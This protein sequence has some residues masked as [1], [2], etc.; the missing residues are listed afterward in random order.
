MTRTSPPQPS[1]SSG[2]LDPLLH[3]RDDY[4][5]YRTGLAKCR[6]FIPLPQGGFTRQPGTLYQ[7]R[8]LSDGAAVLVPFEF[9]ADDAVVLE[10]TAGKM[11]VWRYGALVMNGAGTAPYELATPYDAA[12]LPNL[13]W[14]QSA[15]VVYM[16]DGLRP[17][18]RLARFALNNWTIG[19]QP[20]LSGPFAAQNLDKGKTVQASATTGN[21]TLTANSDL[22]QAG[23]I[24]GLIMLQ[25][26]D[27]TAVAIWTSNTEV[28]ADA[29][30]RVGTRIYRQASGSARTTLQDSPIHEEGIHN[31]GGDILWEFVSDDIGIAQITAISS[32]TVASATVLRA[33]PPGVKDSAT[34]RWS[35]GAWSAQNGYPSAL[36]IYEQRLV[37]AATPSDPRTVWFSTIGAYN[38]FTPGTDADSAFAYT[39]AGSGSINRILN[40]ARGRSGLHIFALGEEHSVRSENRGAPLGPTTAVFG[41]DGSNGTSPAAPI[42]PNGDP[43]VISRD[44]RRVMTVAYSLQ[45]DGNQVAVMSRSAQHLGAETFDQIVWQSS[46]EPMAWLRRGNGEFATMIYDPSE[47]ILGWARASVAGGFV[48]SLC[49][50]K[51]ALGRSDVVTMVVRR[52][53]EGQTRRLIE[54]LAPSYGNLTGEQ[55]IADAVHLFA[56]VE[57]QASPATATFNLPHL[58]GQQV[59]AW[60]DQGQFGPYTVPAG[61]AIT[62]D[63][64]VTR[65]C[66]GL[67]DATHEAE[68]LDLIAAAPDGSSKGRQQRVHRVAIGVHRTAQAEI[69]TLEI[70][71]PEDDRQGAWQAILPLPVAASLTKSFSGV[72]MI[73]L[74]SGNAKQ[75]RLRLRPY[76]GAPMTITALV[77]TVNQA[78]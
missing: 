3:Q 55:P 48:E 65:G 57:I 6:G 78:G 56:A 21:I 25:P 15:D 42:V 28:A 63:A 9:A 10:F 50:T 2:E 29:L 8:T 47:E 77:P 54:T 27:M 70:T 60:T 19:A 41:L 31:Y 53:I 74:P 7:G 46:P 16:V 18:Q 49:V 30:N 39:L 69:A 37:A 67:F 38:D 58:V 52:T 71:L 66:I 12:S 22:W 61:G 35:F 62:L 36:E 23:H 68:T 14:V 1:F 5:R 26:T 75:Q 4:A 24:G 11:R 44:R 20:F 76:G 43:I 34:Y 17:I 73:D 64:P 59:Y 32:A 33:L 13:K 40:V 72:V 51:D 45:A